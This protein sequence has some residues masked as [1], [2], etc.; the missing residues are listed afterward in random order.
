MKNKIKLVIL[1]LVMAFMYI[2]EAKAEC[3]PG[4][5]EGLALLGVIAVLP[6]IISLIFLIRNFSNPSKAIKKVGCTFIIY[7]FTLILFLS[8]NFG[9]L[10]GIMLLYLLIPISIILLITLIIYFISLYRRIHKAD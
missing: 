9:G 2:P 7:F 8:T 6:A 4:L 5:G 3:C 1:L 10:M